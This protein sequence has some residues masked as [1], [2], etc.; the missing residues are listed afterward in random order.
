LRKGAAAPI[1]NGIAGSGLK[2]TVKLL[3]PGF[4]RAN[5]LR[6]YIAYRGLIRTKQER[7]LK[8]I[9]KMSFG[10]ISLLE[11][12][13]KSSIRLRR[14]SGLKPGS[15]AILNQNPIFELGFNKKSSTF[16]M[17]PL[18]GFIAMM[19]FVRWDL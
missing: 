1:C 14:T 13:L 15:A 17:L 19:L 4:V 3:L 5:F 9:L 6:I 18:G 12:R 10:P 11:P 8:P 2:A 7:T 16:M